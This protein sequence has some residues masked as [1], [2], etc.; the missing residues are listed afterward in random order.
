MIRASGTNVTE[1]SAGGTTTQVGG[2]R[3]VWNMFNRV[4][5]ALAVID[6]TDSWTYATNT[7]RQM[8]GATGNKV[9][10]VTGDA[11]VQISVFS[12]GSAGVRDTGSVA[13]MIGLG[14]D[15]TSSPTGT[16]GTFSSGG[17]TSL[18][19][20]TAVWSGTPGLGYHYVS[21][22]EKGGDGSI[23]VFLGDDGGAGTQTGLSVTIAN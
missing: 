23:S 19:T 7:W 6:T 9:E 11:G 8:D 18:S 14:I 5:R 4:P 20:A 3:F 15:S 2:K 1:D 16:T 17:T 21:A 22:L 10:Y 13:N 12:I